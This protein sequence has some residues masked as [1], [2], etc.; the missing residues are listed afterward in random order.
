M[1]WSRIRVTWYFLRTSW[2]F[3]HSSSYISCTTFTNFGSKLFTSCTTWVSSLH[4]Y[5]LII[6]KLNFPYCASSIY[7][8]N[9][10]F[11]YFS[12]FYQI[13]PKLKIPALQISSKWNEHTFP[14]SLKKRSHQKNFKKANPKKGEFLQKE[15]LLIKSISN[16]ISNNKKRSFP[17]NIK[18]LSILARNT[19]EFPPGFL[20]PLGILLKHGQ[21]LSKMISIKNGREDNR[22]I[23]KLFIGDSHFN[24]AFENDIQRIPKISLMEDWRVWRVEAIGATFCHSSPYKF[25]EFREEV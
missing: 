20:I 13:F 18:N 25:R 12:S 17:G 2:I 22:G 7:N 6:L 15:N 1:D 10:S 5:T 21:N 24:R 14:K 4:T 8:N 16:L 3:V 11:G 9:Q 19:R 23:S